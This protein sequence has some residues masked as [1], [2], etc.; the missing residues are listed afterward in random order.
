MANESFNVVFEPNSKKILLSFIILLL[1]LYFAPCKVT[2]ESSIG[3]TA[4]SYWSTC[5]Q[6]YN[7]PSFF[8]SSGASDLHFS[9]FGVLDFSEKAL[10]AMSLSVISAYAVSYFLSS[11]ILFYL[12]KQTM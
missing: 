3:A 4:E 6:L 1:I 7:L 5:G 10:L 12:R 9:F 8:G 2:L 11:L